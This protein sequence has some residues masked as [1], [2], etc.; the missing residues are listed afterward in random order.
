MFY[1][2]KLCSQEMVCIVRYVASPYL[3]HRN[4]QNS[5]VSICI[6]LLLKMIFLTDNSVA[7]ALSTEW[8][9]VESILVAHFSKKY[10]LYH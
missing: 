10:T 7:N 3:A 9:N 4:G 1:V 5:E 8:I 2:I 6:V